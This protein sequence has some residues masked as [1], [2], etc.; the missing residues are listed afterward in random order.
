MKVVLDNNVFI[1]GIFWKN[2]PRQIIQLA[3][4]G[5]VKICSS[6]E[7]LAE[8][9]GV[10]K[11]EKFDYLFQE[12]QVSREIVFQ[13]ILDLVEVFSFK[14]F[15]G[16]PKLQDPKDEMFLSCLIAS[17]ANFLISEDKHLLDLKK[18]QD[19]AIITPAQFLTKF[20]KLCG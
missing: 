15:V 2:K 12:A 9:F 20:S 16:L 13:R 7:I 11:R 5:R 17:G 6:Q 3:E 14:K 4:Q 10:L 8:L 18:F 1:S 19:I